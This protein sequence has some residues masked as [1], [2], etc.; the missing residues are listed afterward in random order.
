MLFFISLLH[1]PVG[2]LVIL[3]KMESGN[4]IYGTGFEITN[5]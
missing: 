2:E 4:A 1:L 5:S 3:G